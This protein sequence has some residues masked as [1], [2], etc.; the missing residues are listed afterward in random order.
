MPTSKQIA[1][2]YT[3]RQ[4]RV[5]R[6]IESQA[7]NASSL[8][9]GADRSLA[10]GLRRIGTVPSGSRQERHV[11]KM[12]QRHYAEE[13]SAMLAKQTVRAGKLIEVEAA[14]HAKALRV[15]LGKAVKI[16]T[17][18]L[19]KLKNV[20]KRSSYNG[21]TISSW[22]GKLA[23]DHSKRVTIAIK[24]G[25]RDGQSMA[26]IM[27]QLERTTFKLAKANAQALTRGGLNHASATSSNAIQKLNGKNIAYLIWDAVLD[28]ATTDICLDRAGQKYTVDHEPIG[29][30]F[31]WEEGPGE[32][33]WGCRSTSIMIAAAA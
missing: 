20:F 22:W 10:A 18:V 28:N 19:S 6:H 25:L 9:G 8:V 11:I 27:T 4:T 26:E 13:Y 3:R 23:K 1:D 29:H 16:K 32:I 5:L 2:M 21:R 24:R 17:P 12:V 15:Q 14:W 30:D 31:A 33:H 7:R